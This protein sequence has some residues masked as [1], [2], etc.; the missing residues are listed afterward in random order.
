MK[1]AI[2]PFIIILI[3]FSFTGILF[4][5]TEINPFEDFNKKIEVL[6][7]SLKTATDKQK[8]A[9]QKKLDKLK[10]QKG[11]AVE[12]MKEPYQKKID[13][14]KKSLEKAKGNKKE[15]IQKKVDLIQKKIL[16]IDNWAAGKGEEPEKKEEKNKQAE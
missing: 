16:Q 4:A 5:V 1:S 7:K 10:E 11:K 8:P 13:G 9:I 2:R 3:I 12:K 6:E 14:M 15:S